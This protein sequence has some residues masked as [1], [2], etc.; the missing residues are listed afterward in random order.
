[1]SK[2][3]KI[4]GV[5]YSTNPNFDYEYEEEEV[6]ETLPPKQQ[7]LKILIDRKLKGGK[8]ATII[9]GFIGTEQDLKDLGKML[10]T[11]LSI[12]G[13]VKNN[14]ILLQGELRDKVIDLLIKAG[15]KTKKSGG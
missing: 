8:T 1:M 2:K 11:K 9:K 4:K 10:K 12:G 7:N 3:K 14:E 5:V 6:Q 15:Y 13:S